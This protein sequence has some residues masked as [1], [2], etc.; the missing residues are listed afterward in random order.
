[1]YTYTYTY[2]NIDKDTFYSETEKYNYRVLHSKVI[3]AR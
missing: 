3:F 2:T 1:M